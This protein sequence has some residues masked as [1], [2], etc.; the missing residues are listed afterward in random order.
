MDSSPFI[1]PNP[2]KIGNE[3]NANGR[4]KDAKSS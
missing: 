2:N 3:I 1:K 4:K